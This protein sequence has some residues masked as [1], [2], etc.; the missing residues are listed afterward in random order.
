[1]VIVQCR[2]FHN[3][4]STILLKKSFVNRSHI[5]TIW[6]KFQL[7]AKTYRRCVAHTKCVADVLAEFVDNVLLVQTNNEYYHGSTFIHCPLASLPIFAT[8]CYWEAMEVDD[9]SA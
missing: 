5:Y 3:I 4:D 6:E 8:D 7:D 9:S 1:M 2:T